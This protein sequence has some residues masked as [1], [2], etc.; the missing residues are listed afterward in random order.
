MAALL[1][2]IV[3]GSALLSTATAQNYGSSSGST[4]GFQYVQPLNTTIYG[5]YGH[6]EPV[7][8][9]RKPVTCPLQGKHLT[10]M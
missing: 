10:V 1:T 2:S 8:P 3:A 5:E 4:G 9:S 7:Y 6:S